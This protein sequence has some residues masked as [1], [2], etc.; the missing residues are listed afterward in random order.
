ME[1]IDPQDVASFNP[2]GLIGGIYVGTTKHCNI[3][4]IYIFVTCGPHGFGED[5]LKFFPMGTICCHQ[6]G[7]IQSVQKPNVVSHYLMM[8]YMKFDYIDYISLDIRDILL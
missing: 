4:I 5:F 1:A 3:F 7:P 8:I 2:R 6:P